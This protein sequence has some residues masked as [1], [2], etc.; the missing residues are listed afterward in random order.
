MIKSSWNCK[1][2]IVDALRLVSHHETGYKPPVEWA[3]LVD[4]TVQETKAALVY[5]AGRVEADKANNSTFKIFGSI[6]VETRQR[7]VVETAVPAL[8]RTPICSLVGG[9]NGYCQ[10]CNGF[11]EE[12]RSLGVDVDRLVR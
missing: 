10:K 8:C 5:L 12:V 7:V 2:R 9:A 1:A 3:R 4:E 11:L 6:A